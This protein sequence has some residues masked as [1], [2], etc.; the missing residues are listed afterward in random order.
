MI[1][2]RLLAKNLKNFETAR[3]KHTSCVTP[4]GLSLITTFFSNTYLGGHLRGSWLQFATGVHIWVHNCIYTRKCEITAIL[5]K[6]VLY[7][8][9]AG[10][11]P[12]EVKWV[13]FHLPP[14]FFLFSFHLNQALVLLQYYKNSPPIS[15][16]WIRA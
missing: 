10:A 15:K 4:L 7:C 14:S 13:N 16:S 5:L 2:R 9:S 11:D 1:I 8:L 6:I 12:G 3:T